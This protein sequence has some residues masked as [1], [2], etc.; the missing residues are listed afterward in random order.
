MVLPNFLI[1][2]AAKAGTTSLYAY[3]KQHPDIYM[4][5]V[6]EPRFFA[7][8]VF[9]NYNEV[10]RNGARRVP[11]TFE[12]YQELFA[13]V[14][15]ET[16][17]GEASTEY[18]YFPGVPARIKQS[19]PD[20]K[21]IAVLR[22]PVERAFSAYCYQLRD[23]C[24]P[25]SFEE[26]LIAEADRIK[27]GY[28]PGWHYQQPGFYS[29]QVK[30]YLDTFDRSQIKIYLQDDLVKDSVKVSQDIYKFLGVDDSFVPDI[31]R[32]NISGVPK[33]KF[34]HSIF[35]QDNP[36][37]SLVKPLLPLKMRQNIYQKVRKNNLTSKPTLAGET[38]QQLTELYRKDIEQLQE[39][40][41]V[42]LSHWLNQ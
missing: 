37:K 35:T 22:N 1:I 18:L 8:E 6:K 7:P 29:Q 14:T 30:R 5:E 16:A 19:I 40:L 36:L 3:L 32:K 11:F 4:S 21:L 24:E 27:Q 26:A 28:R 10:A 25:L 42:D 33:N 17:I 41:S 15:D 2:G 31:T 12:E 9:T 34:L 20:I 13:G 38:R 39:I 23:N